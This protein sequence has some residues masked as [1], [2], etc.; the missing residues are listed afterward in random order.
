[1]TIH[2]FDIDFLVEILKN[3]HRKFDEDN[4]TVC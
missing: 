4:C 1:M 3:S 2:L